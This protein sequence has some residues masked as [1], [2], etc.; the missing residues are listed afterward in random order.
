MAAPVMRDHT[1]AFAEKEQH[2]VVPVV[3]AQWPTVMEHDGLGVARSPILV[4]KA[5]AILCR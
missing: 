5:G 1:V 3:G 4:E 2:L